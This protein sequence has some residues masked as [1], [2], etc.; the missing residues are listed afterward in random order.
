MAQWELCLVLLM[1]SSMKHLCLDDSSNV[2]FCRV[3]G[4]ENHT[5][6]HGLDNLCIMLFSFSRMIITNYIIK[7]SSL[8]FKTKSNTSPWKFIFS[9][10]SDTDITKFNDLWW[11]WSITVI[12]H[13]IIYFLSYFFLFPKIQ[14][15]LSWI[16]LGLRNKDFCFAQFILLELPHQLYC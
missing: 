9:I 6:R 11:H 8:S 2:Y 1:S 13:G 5:L 12:M 10:F 15:P 4:S 14:H 7:I 16:E 3:A